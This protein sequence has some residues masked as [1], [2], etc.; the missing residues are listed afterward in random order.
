[1][2]IRLVTGFLDGDNVVGFLTMEILRRHGIEPGDLLARGGEFLSVG[3]F[4]SA[5]LVLSGGADAMSEEGA[6]SEHFKAMFRE[7]ALTC[8]SLEPRVA[9]ELEEEFGWK[10][11]VVPAGVYEGQTEPMLAPDYSTWVLCAREDLDED[12]ACAVARS[13]LD[14]GEELRA[15]HFHLSPQLSWPFPLPP[16]IPSE[17][18]DTAPVPLHAGSARLYRERGLL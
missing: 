11:M 9:K 10:S 2:P 7:K 4:N 16:L 8:L 14:H 5:G 13:V 1:M 6:F 3:V 15:G 17:I 12:I 18:V